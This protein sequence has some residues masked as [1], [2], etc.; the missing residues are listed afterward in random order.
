MNF[1]V[2]HSNLSSLQFR[3]AELTT[4][5]SSDMLSYINEKSMF[6]A[7]LPGVSNVWL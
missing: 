3:K 6:E 4:L 1:K 5:R 7:H 2:L